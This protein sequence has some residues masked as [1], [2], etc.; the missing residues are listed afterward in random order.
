VRGARTARPVLDRLVLTHRAARR[1]GT[2]TSRGSLPSNPV[3]HTT[4]N[5][6]WLRI[7]AIVLARRVGDNVQPPRVRA[8]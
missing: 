8:G 1:A 4:G 2:R 6:R 5:P 3:A 7:R